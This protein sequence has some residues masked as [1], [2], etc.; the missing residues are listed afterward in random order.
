[1]LQ[2]EIS[3][4]GTIQN[5]QLISGHRCWRRRRLRPVKQWRYKPYLLN[6]EPVAWRRQVVVTLA[7][8]EA[9]S[10]VSKFPEFQ[11]CKVFRVI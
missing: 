4:D 7:C 5:L 1:V 9:R 3:K 8:P 6:G 2:A 11:G 10:K